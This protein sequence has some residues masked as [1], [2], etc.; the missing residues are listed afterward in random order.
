MLLC[1]L[2]IHL[3]GESLLTKYAFVSMTYVY[4]NKS[5]GASPLVTSPFTNE[6]LILSSTHK[7]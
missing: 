4:S 7:M 6:H 5:Q 2:D 3:N 1:Y